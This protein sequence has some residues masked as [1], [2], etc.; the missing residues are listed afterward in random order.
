MGMPDTTDV[1]PWRRALINVHSLFSCSVI[2]SALLGGAAQADVVSGVVLDATRFRAYIGETS[3]GV[4]PWSYATETTHSGNA[5]TDTFRWKRTDHDD[6]IKGRVRYTEYSDSTKSGMNFRIE[7]TTELSHSTTAALE[8][9]FAGVVNYNSEE[10]VNFGFNGLEWLGSLE[11]IRVEGTFTP[12]VPN[13]PDRTFDQTYTRDNTPS[14]SEVSI[15]SGF[16]QGGQDNWSFSIK[17]K[18]YGLN[19]D[20]APFINFY[21]GSYADG[22][23]PVPGPAM[24]LSMVLGVPGLARGRRRS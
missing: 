11:K 23:I 5:T 4:S 14:G 21:L 7:Q 15:L 2:A 18:A 6:S 22:A 3:G 20:T 8:Y 9:E 24:M 10:F 13:E 19:T 16:G 12:G 17:V 1:L